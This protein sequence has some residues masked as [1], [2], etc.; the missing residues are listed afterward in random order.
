MTKDRV[1]RGLACHVTGHPML[2]ASIRE[3]GG[4]FSDAA[5][6]SAVDLDLS[7][8]ADAV[9]TTVLQTRET[10]EALLSAPV[11]ERVIRFRP[12]AAAAERLALV[13]AAT[14]SP[15]QQEAYA[16]ALRACGYAVVTTSHAAPSLPL[17]EPTAIAELFDVLARAAV[18]VA[19]PGDVALAAALSSDATL[20]AVGR[21]FHVAFLSP[22]NPRVFATPDAS[23]VAHLFRHEQELGATVSPGTCYVRHGLVFTLGDRLYRTLRAGPT[24]ADPASV[25]AVAQELATQ[26]VMPSFERA[27]AL[28]G[29]DGA[30]TI[31]VRRVPFVTRPAEWS[32][33]QTA[34]AV[35]LLLDLTTQL[36]DRADP[37]HL[38]DPH[39]FNVTFDGPRPVYLD[40]GSLR[41]G[42][43]SVST[44]QHLRS[45][46][47]PALRRALPSAAAALHDALDVVV[48]SPLWEVQR[49]A[50]R[51]AASQLRAVSPVHTA[52]TN[53]SGYAKPLPASLA[54]YAE[55]ARTSHKT[56]VPFTML[57]RLHPRTVTDFGANTG[58]F[59]R[60]AAYLGAAVLAT[61]NVED[62]V[63]RGY[64]MAEAAA[65]PITFAHVDLLALPPAAGV[66]GRLQPLDARW[67]ADLVLGAAVT[68]HLARAGMTFDAMAALFASATRDHLLVEF[69]P[70]TDQYVQT[71]RMPAWYTEAHFREAFSMYFDLD[72]PVPSDPS[73]R[74]WYAGRRRPATPFTRSSHG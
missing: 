21:A 62:V 69:I 56:Q 73:P 32:A 5:G 8:G 57:R 9:W 46:V 6:T 71:W 36:G 18:V 19:G 33:S 59:A 63:D 47:L 11:A 37:W 60:L 67:C 74:V 55:D 48:A 7:G 50:L 70:P 43:P 29:A 30:R 45:D 12:T 58:Y 24:L 31:A 66:S 38:D 20:C 65:L 26:G 23:D 17:D 15:R 16:E 25:L 51:S 44:W 42:R 27:P 3:L 39:L 2:A 41:P 68:H 61:D 14:L 35:A 34:A 64:R 4:T 10:A 1:A 53:W 72:A 54:A 13:D 28:E 49:G 22:A 40:F 52:H